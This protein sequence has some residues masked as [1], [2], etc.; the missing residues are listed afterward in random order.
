MNPVRRQT[1]NLKKIPRGSFIW[2]LSGLFLISAH[3]QAKPGEATR[4]SNA[5]YGLS[6]A[7]PDDMSLFTVE[8]PG[9]MSSLLSENEPILLVRNSFSEESINWSIIPRAS[10]SDLAAYKSQL[11]NTPTLDLPEYKRVSVS[12]ITIGKEKKKSAIEHIYFMK[13]N[14]KGELRSIA[15]SHRGRGFIVVCAT[16]VDRYAKTNAEI[17]Q[18]IFDS[19]EFY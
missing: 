8:K 6:F 16:A 15:F 7:I 10:E 2:L 14:I 11:D 5:T 17:F 13:G 1:V 9:R 12:T 3:P 19:M 4:Y 18:Y